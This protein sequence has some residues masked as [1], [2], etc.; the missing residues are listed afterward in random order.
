MTNPNSNCRKE[1]EFK[2][3]CRFSGE[4]S[5]GKIRWIGFWPTFLYL[6][7]IPIFAQHFGP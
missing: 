6:T 2:I 7:I 3:V 1:T 5:R 4:V